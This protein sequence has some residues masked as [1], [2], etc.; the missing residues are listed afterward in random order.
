MNCLYSLYI[1]ICVTNCRNNKRI[2]LKTLLTLTLSKKK[3]LDQHNSYSHSGSDQT[4]VLYSA[5]PCLSMGQ[6]KVHI[7]S[8]KG[9]FTPV[10]FGSIE[11]NSSSFPPL[12]RIFWAGVNTAI[13]LWCAPNN[14]TETQLKRWSRSASK[15][16]LVWSN[17]WTNEWMTLSTRVVLFTVSGSLAKRAVW[18]QTAPNKRNQHCIWSGSKQVN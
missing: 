5:I 6:K 11:S 16:T 14:H 8:F 15:R 10:L 3:S 1:Y 7:H 18:K 13:A 9:V 2:E 12:V 17:G 4:Q